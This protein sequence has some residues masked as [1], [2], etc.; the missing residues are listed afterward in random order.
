MFATENVCGF[1][2]HGK[3]PLKL[4]M[5]YLYSHVHQL[6]E[7][8]QVVDQEVQCRWDLYYADGVTDV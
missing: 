7:R 2:L 8:F 6:A 3:G 5:F 1:C 4:A